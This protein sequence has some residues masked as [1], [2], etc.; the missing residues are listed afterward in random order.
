MATHP[1]P[2]GPDGLVQFSDDAWVELLSAVDR[3]D[4]DLVSHEKQLERQNAE[5][6]DMRTFLTAILFSVS[7]VLS[8]ADRR[9]CMARISRSVEAPKGHADASLPGRTLAEL[10]E[11]AARGFLAEALQRI[12]ASR[13][14]VGLEANFLA[15]GGVEPLDLFI[16]P[17]LDDRGRVDG[18]VLT[19]RTL[20]T[21]KKVYAELSEIHDTLQ[22]AL[23]FL[24]GRVAEARVNALLYRGF[25]RRL[26]GRDPRDALVIKPRIWGICLI[27]QSAT[28][29][30][31]AGATGQTPTPAGAGPSRTRPWPPPPATGA[32]PRGWP[33][34]GGRSARWPAR[35][36]T[37]T[38]W[39]WPAAASWPAS[40][41]AR[42]SRPGTSLLAMRAVCRA[43]WMGWRSQAR[44]HRRFITSCA[45]SIPAW[46]APRSETRARSK[47]FLREFRAR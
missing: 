46:S 30:T 32:R 25:E 19:G 42:S 22:L 29:Q 16:A 37:A 11:T 28:A 34:R 27:S 13:K 38:R 36:W 40:P 26:E 23:E 18:F 7:D 3:T 17:R 47:N 1:D 6:Q 14:G 21:L 9:G 5:L 4:A 39:R 24:A 20:G 12:C 2:L 33:G 10:F 44:C 45:V 31:L 8:L 35:W 43:R 41:A 15:P